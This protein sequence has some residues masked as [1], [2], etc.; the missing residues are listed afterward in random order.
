MEHWE[1]GDLP[2]GEI[3]IAI[4]EFLSEENADEVIA[5]LPE[6]YRTEFLDWSHYM[7]GMPPGQWKRIPLGTFTSPLAEDQL[8]FPRRDEVHRALSSWFA[9]HAG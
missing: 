9:R 7:I 8:S 4:A 6:P 1:N 2:R 3:P 5:D